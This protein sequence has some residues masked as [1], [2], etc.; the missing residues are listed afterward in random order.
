VNHRKTRLQKQ[1]DE[2]VR[3]AWLKNQDADDIRP[4]M[5]VSGEICVHVWKNGS[6]TLEHTEVYADE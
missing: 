4:Q 3:R 5:S 1:K 2:A 6:A